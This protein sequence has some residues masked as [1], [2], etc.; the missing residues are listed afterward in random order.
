[1]V[2]LLL[3]LELV[4]LAAVLH[5]L[6][7]EKRSVSMLIWIGFI[8]LFPGIGLIVY[9]LIGNDRVRRRRFKHHRHQFGDW[10]QDG[11]SGEQLAGLSSE[12]KILLTAVS[13][14]CRHPIT[15]IRKIEAYFSGK[16][17]YPDLTAMIG[18]ARQF[19][20]IETYQWRDDATGQKILKALIEA[21]QRGVMVRLLVDEIGSI[22]VSERFFK[23]LV[24]A[25][26]RF[27]WFNT[28]HPRRNRYFFNLR[29]HRKLYIIDGEVAF[30]GGI[31]I[32]DEYEGKDASLGNWKDL[33]IRLEG[34]VVN[35]LQEVF[36]HDWYF[37]TEQALKIDA[38]APPDEKNDAF[39]AVVVESGPD[40]Q[41]GVALNSL[42][43]MIGQAKDRADLFTPYFV[44]EPALINALQIAAAK[45]VNVRLMVSKKN[46]HGFLV[47][48]GRS[49]Y[50]ELLRAGARIFEY[51]RAIHHAK[52]VIVDQKW[53]LTGSANLD[54]RS[55]NLNFEV[56]VLFRS[57]ELYRQ[58]EPYFEHMFEDAI[59][60]DHDRFA[61]R[62]TYQRLKQNTLRLWA[63]LL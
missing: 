20:H 14:L 45:G 23:P 31:N 11:T 8:L 33:Q 7:S 63:P 48:I 24:Q 41:K 61:K 37:A 10:R 18:T 54:A 59:E 60:I 42:L 22:E 40:T 26:G 19:V 38:V 13:R 46:D 51:D 16:D 30:V 27:S 43:A 6:L 12:D 55:M 3:F 52:L 15:F 9:T 49:Y 56:G 62:S 57:V 34:E 47:N 21:A 44:P 4:S 32:G 36:R 35:H 53:L 25:G 17:F 29:N 5:V 1:M 2:V 28:F 39:P 50:D 58:I